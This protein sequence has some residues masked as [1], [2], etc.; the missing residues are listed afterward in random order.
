[1]EGHGSVNV[2]SENMTENN[3]TIQKG[4]SP[5]EGEDEPEIID[6]QIQNTPNKSATEGPAH[7]ELEELENVVIKITTPI[8]C[9]KKVIV[10]AFSE[11]SVMVSANVS[12]EDKGKPGYI[13]P[14]QN[15]DILVTTPPQY[16]QCD[17][18]MSIDV[19]NGR[20]VH[21][22][23][24]KGLEM[25]NLHLERQEQLLLPGDLNASTGN[26]I[27]SSPLPRPAED[28]LLMPQGKHEPVAR[29]K[30]RGKQGATTDKPQ[31]STLVPHQVIPTVIAR[32]HMNR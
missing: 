24:D 28:T 3:S 30:P 21:V 15:E 32:M 9:V 2:I 8:Q 29:A 22:T 13:T 16:V 20:R 12:K 7:K 14:S 17:D 23:L 27:D 19:L 10:P 11:M 4:P 31:S 18:I 26:N 25:G 1:M 6:Q 5:T